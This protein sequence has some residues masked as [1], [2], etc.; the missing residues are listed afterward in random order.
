MQWKPSK[1]EASESIYICL[2]LL[3][4][5]SKPKVFHFPNSKCMFMTRALALSS[6]SMWIQQIRCK[7]Q[8]LFVSHSL[9]LFLKR[10]LYSSPALLIEIDVKSSPF[11]K[12]IRFFVMI[13]SGPVLTPIWLELLFPYQKPCLMFN[14][15]IYLFSMHIFSTYFSA[16]FFTC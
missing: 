14:I 12:K 9:G 3:Q 15:A 5:C 4:G 6:Q 8:D 11:F 2:T 1:Q 10:E 16:S 13:S 7:V